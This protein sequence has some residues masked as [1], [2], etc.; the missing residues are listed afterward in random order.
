MCVYFFLEAVPTPAVSQRRSVTQTNPWP[1]NS[2]NS[3]NSKIRSIRLLY[4]VHES[5]G[6][7]ASNT[8]NP[9]RSLNRTATQVKTQ[10]R[11][12]AMQ[13]TTQEN[14][15]PPKPK[16]EP[17]GNSGKN[18]RETDGNAG[19]DSGEPRTERTQRTCKKA[20]NPSSQDLE[21]SMPQQRRR[22]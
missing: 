22:S 11:P 8:N 21:C 4:T 15:P 9:R 1:T 20:L 2:K 18:P 6:K 17:K 3:S 5:D 7:V 16:P 10:E 13:E 14:R 19:T 12:L